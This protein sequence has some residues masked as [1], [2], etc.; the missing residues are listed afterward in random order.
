MT[1]HRA[2]QVLID[3][4]ERTSMTNDKLREAFLSIE[5]APVRI[6]RSRPRVWPVVLVLLGAIVATMFLIGCGVQ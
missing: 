5:P 2:H 6:P 1:N 3:T 4:H